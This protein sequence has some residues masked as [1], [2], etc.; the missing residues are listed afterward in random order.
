MKKRGYGNLFIG[1][2]VA[3]IALGIGY[4]AISAIPLIINGSATAKANGTDADF[5]V[6]FNDFTNGTNYLSYTETTAT[7]GSLT[8]SIVSASQ[9]SGTFTG[10]DKA[11]SVSVAANQ[12]SADVTV[13]NLENLGDTF[14]IKIPVINDSDGIG[15]DLSVD[16][17]NSNTDY[18]TVTSS[19]D[20]ALIESNGG[21]TY[22]NITVALK[23]VPKVDDINGTFTVTLTADPSEE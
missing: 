8:Q 18:F 5:D 11:V 12:M 21:N 13:S 9:V 19:L 6:H 16:V 22:V 23:R 17:T 20:D 4:A 2:L 14:T 15:A 7:T 1:M 10:S 3:V